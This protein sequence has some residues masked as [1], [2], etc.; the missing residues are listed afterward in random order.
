MD[1][2]N[3]SNE[4]INSTA[5]TEI[6]KIK[7]SKLKI[8]MKKSKSLPNIKAKSTKLIPK[9]INQKIMEQ[10][11][12]SDEKKVFNNANDYE[13]LYKDKRNTRFDVLWVKFLRNFRYNPKKIIFNASKPPSFYEKDVERYLKRVKKKKNNTIDIS[14]SNKDRW[15]FL[16]LSEQGREKHYNEYLPHLFNKGDKLI[17]DDERLYVDK[18]T[19]NKKNKYLYPFEYKFRK[20]KLANGNEIFQKFIKY[21]EGR[22][23]KTPSL[24]FSSNT[25]N[26]KFKIKNCNNI[27]DYLK[28]DHAFDFVRWQT[29]LRS[30][31]KKS[32]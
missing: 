24:L 25:Y 15:I 21:D 6:S 10:I 17:Q 20:I 16:N 7:I 26:D 13:F 3:K 32:V 28:I 22:T 19:L 9:S 31:K 27:K 14:P 2:L 8:N 23:L 11:K 5:A 12:L 29:N 4:I 30:Y 18:E 1:L